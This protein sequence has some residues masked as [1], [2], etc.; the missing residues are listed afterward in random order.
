MQH[1]PHPTDRLHG[2]ARHF[3][4]GAPRTDR[5]YRFPVHAGLYDL[6]HTAFENMNAAGVPLNVMHKLAG[7]AKGDNIGSI[8][9]GKPRRHPT[10]GIV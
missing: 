4:T 1:E 9:C 10:R 6:R 8:N 7:H 2:A 5:D 3:R